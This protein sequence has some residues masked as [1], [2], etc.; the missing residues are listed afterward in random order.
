[1]GLRFT[2]TSRLLL[3]ACSVLVLFM[4]CSRKPDPEPTW[5]FGAKGIRISYTA[6]KLLNV[7]KDKPHT[8]LLIVYQLDNV[9]VFN[10]FAGY[11]GGL[12]RLLKAQSFDPSVMAVDKVFIEPAESTTMVLNRAENAKWIGIVAGYYDLAPG[13]VSRSLEI[14]FKV[15][16]KGVI[17]RKRIAEVDT[18]HVNLLLGPH[19]IQEIKQ[20]TKQEIK[21]K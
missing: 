17:R 9:N 4:S 7:V 14:P 16:T 21:K 1:M 12:E 13:K 15:K 8:L 6:P 11:K 2:K 3:I 19:S 5:A 10:K 18:L 20:E